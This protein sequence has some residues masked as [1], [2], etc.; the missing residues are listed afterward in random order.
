MKELRELHAAIR[1]A[2][3]E[4]ASLVV[5]ARIGNLRVVPR[6]LPT[7]RLSPGARPASA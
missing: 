5:I 4:C 7:M 1:E 6:W 3:I 2:Y